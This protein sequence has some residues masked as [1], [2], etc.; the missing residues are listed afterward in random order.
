MITL[1]VGLV[2]ALCAVRAVFALLNREWL[3]AAASSSAALAVVMSGLALFGRHPWASPVGTAL[4]LGAAAAGI[5]ARRR[6]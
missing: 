4:L 2:A 5:A 6:A 3:W 1:A